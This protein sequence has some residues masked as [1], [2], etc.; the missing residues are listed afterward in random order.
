V[1]FTFRVSVSNLQNFIIFLNRY[2]NWLLVVF[3][4]GGRVE[5]VKKL[6]F[7][8]KLIFP[9]WPLKRTVSLYRKQ[10]SFQRRLSTPIPHLG[11]E[12]KN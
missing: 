6:E 1:G 7:F 11:L 5:R 9:I 3:E 2:N 4:A 10:T 8:N 12:G